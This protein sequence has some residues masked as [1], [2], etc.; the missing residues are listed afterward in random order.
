FCL[1]KRECLAP[2]IALRVLPFERLRRSSARAHWHGENR[3]G[4]SYP[5]N[6]SQVPRPRT[7]HMSPATLDLE[8]PPVST[9]RLL[10]RRNATRCR[11]IRLE[12]PSPRS[13]VASSRDIQ[14]LKS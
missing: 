11:R 13:A 8:M 3:S 6:L 7:S 5:R 10:L 14:E 1:Q 12:L 4:N 9:A 2:P